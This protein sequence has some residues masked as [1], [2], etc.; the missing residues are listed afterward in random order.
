MRVAHLPAGVFERPPRHVGEPKGSSPLQAR[1][2]RAVGHRVP[3]V[4][5]R[6]RVDDLRV[7]QHPFAESVRHGGDGEDAAQT[8]IKSRLTHNSV[9]LTEPRPQPR[10]RPRAGGPFT[11][12][13]ILLLP[14]T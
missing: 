11:R 3:L 10:P 5:L 9:L 8:Y 13:T 6:V 14:R 1:Q 4:Q 7:L 2:P 12:R